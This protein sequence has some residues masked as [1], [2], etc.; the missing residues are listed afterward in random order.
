ML[1]NCPACQRLLSTG[2]RHEDLQTISHISHSELVKCTSCLTFYLHEHDHWE[3]LSANNNHF[4][5]TVAAQY[6]QLLQN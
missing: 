1:C 6:D 5:P 4:L 2:R 3:P